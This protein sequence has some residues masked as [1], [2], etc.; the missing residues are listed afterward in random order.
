MSGC[1]RPFRI[2]VGGSDG[3]GA[4]GYVAAAYELLQQC[5]SQ[6]FEPT[7]IVLVTGSAGTH[8]GL[9]AGLR[10]AG[11]RTAVI[12]I[13]CSGRAAVQQ[14]R[15]RRVLDDLAQRV[16]LPAALA[17][18]EIIVHD[19]WRGPGYAIPSESGIDAIRLAARTEGLLLDPVYTGK[20]MAGLIG[21]ARRGA[22][23]RDDK[24]VF[25]HTGGA[26]AL[27]AYED[28]FSPSPSALLAEG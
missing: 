28:S 9:L 14:S 23:S 8:A 19:D 16:G 25:L 3:I 7:S 6:Y 22:F 26:P 27:F 5:R 21:L 12:G 24:V 11:A 13:S 18:E 2:P 10:A 15:V 1:R 17:G 20:G 4:V